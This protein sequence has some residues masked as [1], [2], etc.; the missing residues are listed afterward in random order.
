[1]PLYEYVC[2]TC[3]TR[4]ERLRPMARAGDGADCPHCE[5]PARRVLSVFAAFTAGGGD[6]EESSAVAGTGG[7]M[8]CAGG[9]CACGH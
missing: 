9:A 8:A 6:G 3:S 7:C 1:M 4:F 5:A 2:Q